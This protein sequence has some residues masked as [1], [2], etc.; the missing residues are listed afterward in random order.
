VIDV[1]QS[2]T[3]AEVYG[4]VAIVD[5]LGART[6]DIHQATA[7]LEARRTI[8]ARVRQAH[9][10]FH[11]L[12]RGPGSDL[13]MH[14]EVRTFGDTVVLAWRFSEASVYHAGNVIHAALAVMISEGLIAKIAWRGAI[15]IGSYV[16]DETSVLGPAVSDAAA[17]YEE[18]DWIGVVATPR[19]KEILA[20]HYWG[21]GNGY[22]GWAV[23]Y[24]KRAGS[25]NLIAVDWPRELV[26]KWIRP[27]PLGYGERETPLPRELVPPTVHQSQ[28]ELAK[29]F[30]QFPIPFGTESKYENTRRFFEHELADKLSR[31]EEAQEGSNRYRRS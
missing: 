19:T 10:A 20:A 22:V 9:N 15:A 13:A 7:F 5:A 18:L 4:A 27:K 16:I 2:E 3:G 30:S 14:L 23:P 11:V 28:E 24:S 31:L 1:R 6:F 8:E 12:R 25:A 17:W 26:R 29:L 21:A